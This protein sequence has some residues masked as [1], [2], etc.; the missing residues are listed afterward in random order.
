[1][2]GDCLDVTGGGS[3]FSVL[4]EIFVPVSYRKVISDEHGKCSLC[5]GSHVKFSAEARPYACLHY[6]G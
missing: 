3:T 4:S 1:M 2:V 5:T 6:R